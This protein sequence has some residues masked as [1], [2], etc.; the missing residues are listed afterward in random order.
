MRTTM[1]LPVVILLLGCEFHVPPDDPRRARDTSYDTSDKIALDMIVERLDAEGIDYWID[2][3]GRIRFSTDL[4][5]KIETIAEQ[6]FDHRNSGAWIQ[7]GGSD[8]DRM[9]VMITILEE[10]GIEYQV[11]PLG[12]ASAEP[13]GRETVPGDMIH[14]YPTEE[15]NE[16]VISAEVE[17]V[18]SG[19]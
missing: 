1:L 12:G 14:W 13:T 3:K 18:C 5:P 8:C 19:D 6:V 7:Y 16:D 17:R 2:E 9:A 10:R 4:R 11:E 15:Y